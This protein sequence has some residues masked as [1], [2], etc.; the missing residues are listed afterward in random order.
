M[1]N[2]LLVA[3][4]GA[5]KTNLAIFSRQDGPRKP[6]TEA[7]FS[8]EDYEGL[9]AV[10]R[11]FL[12]DVDLSVD[13]ACIGVAGPVIDG[14]ARGTNLPSWTIDE[15]EVKEALDLSWVRVLNDLE[16]MANAVPILE[17]E[18]VETLNAG[19]P[20]SHGPVGVVAPGT[21]LGEGF[22][23]WDGSRYRAYASEGGHTDF[24]PNNAQ[25]RGL[26]AHL[27]ERFGHVSY[28]RVCSGMGISNIYGYLK[29]SGYVDEPAWI[30]EQLEGVE[31]KT[32]I[33]VET[34]MDPE[35]ECPLCSTTL[36]MFIS[37]LGAEAGNL[38]LK[39]VATGGIYLGGGIPPRI[40]PALKE[41][42]FMKGFL[43]KGRMEYVVEKIPV[44]VILTPKAPLWG[45]AYY[46]L[47]A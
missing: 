20:V 21:G 37:I 24:G 6:L 17:E 8:S 16:V 45:A 4:I 25:E 29:V 5:T 30:A 40:L 43:T 23:V 19:R 39:L 10:V 44:Y 9:E 35:K 14:R 12:E 33:I 46:G 47:E 11:E 42:T 1:T 32:P 13:S 36:E 27:C 18:D 41:D 3:D 38:A 22:L 28:E 26:L 2:M 15:R 31:D 34:A 7:S